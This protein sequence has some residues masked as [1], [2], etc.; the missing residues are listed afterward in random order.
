M[1]KKTGE[2]KEKRLMKIVATTSLPAVDSPNADRWNA[3]CSC[4]NGVMLGLSY[5]LA[6]G[7]L[8]Y[9]EGKYKLILIKL[10]VKFKLSLAMKGMEYILCT[11][12]SSN[13]SAMM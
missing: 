5:Q 11:V 1:R 2:K 8:G 12:S 3:A 10:K 13:Y 7:E 4:Q 6:S 9:F